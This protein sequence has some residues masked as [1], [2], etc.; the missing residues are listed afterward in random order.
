M[1]RECVYMQVILGLDLLLKKKSVQWSVQVTKYLSE[2]E[3]QAIVVVFNWW[4]G[5][6]AAQ[7]I[8]I[9]DIVSAY[10]IFVSKMFHILY[11]FNIVLC[12]L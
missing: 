4:A 6:R 3:E 8:E 10:A 5:T 1:E 2:C 12:T 9:T 11:Y 7:H